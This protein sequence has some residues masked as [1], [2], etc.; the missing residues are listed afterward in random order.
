[1]KWAKVE[2]I[3]YMKAIKLEWMSWHDFAM[4]YQHPPWHS[5][6]IKVSEIYFFIMK[7]KVNIYEAL[8]TLKINGIATGYRYMDIQPLRFV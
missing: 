3:N 4:K 6:T 2:E 1:M 5:A 8:Q 7:M